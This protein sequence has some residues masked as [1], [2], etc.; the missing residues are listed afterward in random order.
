MSKRQSQRIR[1]LLQK[2]ISRRFRNAAAILQWANFRRFLLIAIRRHLFRVTPI[3]L[4]RLTSNNSKCVN[5]ANHTCLIRAHFWMEGL[6][7][8]MP[9]ECEFHLIVLV[10][11]HLF[12][13]FS[14]YMEKDEFADDFYRRMSMRDMEPLPEPAMSY[15]RDDFPRHAFTAPLP[16]RS[17]SMPDAGDFRRTP[18]QIPPGSMPPMRRHPV[19]RESSYQNAIMQQRYPPQSLARSGSVQSDHSSHSGG[20]SLHM[21]AGY[22]RAGSSDIGSTSTPL[23]DY[24]EDFQDH[25]PVSPHFQPKYAPPGY[26]PGS[27]SRFH[28]PHPRYIPQQSA[29]SIPA[30]IPRPSPPITKQDN[31]IVVSTIGEFVDAWQTLELEGA[32][33]PA[34]TKAPGLIPFSSE[35]VW[36]DI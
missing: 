7:N 8:A 10:S 26:D 29:S 11:T 28:A 9:W 20:Q 36:G 34:E 18:P 13:P 12:S 30:R 32:E 17:Q 15:R 22:A 25:S 4:V 6:T 5:S 3:F 31:E 2:C 27:P 23:E 16:L 24:H 14:R 19:T 21:V 1:L 35:T 33:R